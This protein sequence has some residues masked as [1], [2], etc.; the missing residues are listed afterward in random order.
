MSFAFAG[1]AC[2]SVLAETKSPIRCLDAGADEKLQFFVDRS[3]PNAGGSSVST[4]ALNLAGGVNRDAEVSPLLP[5]A[6]S[7]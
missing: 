5:W 4:Q 7:L 1:A 6:F 3:F 2:V